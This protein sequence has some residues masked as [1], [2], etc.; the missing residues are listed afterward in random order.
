MTMPPGRVVRAPL[1]VLALLLA[2]CATRW[3]VQAAPLA[4]VLKFNDTSDFLVTRTNGSQVELRD[5][6][7]EHDSLVGIEKADP[8]GP[9]AQERR[10]IAL[11]DVKQIAVREADG[12][13]TVFWVALGGLFVVFMSFAA[14]MSGTGGPGS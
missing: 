8:T 7:I 10:A 4:D 12:V 6:V 11:T 1:H 2:G 5:P 9:D 3:Q 13:A 14:L